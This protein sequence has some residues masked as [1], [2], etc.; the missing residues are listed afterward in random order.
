[1]RRCPGSGA[2]P[3]VCALGVMVAGADNILINWV[4]AERMEKTQ[5]GNFPAVSIGCEVTTTF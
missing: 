3:M 1:M 4:I 2:V 5:S